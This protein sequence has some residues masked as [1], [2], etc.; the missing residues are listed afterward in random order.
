MLNSIRPYLS[1]IHGFKTKKKRDRKIDFENLKKSN[2]NKTKTKSSLDDIT[3]NDL[4]M[5]SLFELLNYTNC[6]AG[7]ETLYSWLK[8]PVDNEIDYNSRLTKINQAEKRKNEIHELKK[9]FEKMAYCKYHFEEVIDSEYKSNNLSLGIH[10]ILTIINIVIIVQTLIHGISALLG[11][12][13]VLFPVNL[14]LHNLFL[15]KN[16][17]QLEVLQYAIKL[18]KISKK[19]LNRINQIS[20]QTSDS[21][22]I[23]INRLKPIMN[24]ETMLFRLEG[25]DVLAD[26]LNIVFSIKEINY[27]LIANKV[28]K[29]SAD[30]KH[31]YG[32][33]GELDAVISVIAYRDKLYNY[34]EPEIISSCNS[35]TI[36]EMYHPL[37]SDVISNSIITSSDVAI[38]GSNMSGKSTFLRT[39]GVN[40]ILAQS[41]CT[42][43]AKQY[44]TNY[45][46]VITSISLNDTLT[47]AKSYFLVE[48]EAIKRMI[49]IRKDD[50]CTLILIDEI[51]KGTNPIERYAASMEILNTLGEG[52]T[53]VLV[54]THDMNILDELK[55][56]EYYY[57]TEN[58]SK[59]ELDFDY[60]IR[61]GIANTRNAIKIL[62]YVNYPIEIL[63]SINERINQSE[64]I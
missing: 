34:C 8:N 38:T 6:S 44:K 7:E 46:R 40:A 19:N 45:F 39:V 33:I 36:K 15:R 23:S 41:I 11:I 31:L 9:A 14:I 43:L 21:V 32:Q 64:G 25:L 22:T 60:K 18:I 48:A 49:D 42:C 5:D 61:P 59:D 63:D 27:Y 62:D 1:Y 51:F 12:L 26:Y 2:V 56:Y 35:L 20:P 10:C 3:W 16:G 13:L 55:G 29:M 54:S 17:V 4:N 58:V 37:L 57:F 28:N 30:I 50:Y 52:N 53:K 24:K 47:N